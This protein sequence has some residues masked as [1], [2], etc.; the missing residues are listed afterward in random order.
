M[1]L[2]SDDARACC[3]AVYGSAAARF[4][5]GDSF[6]PGGARLSR[7][8]LEALAPR[9]ADTILDV[10]SG[11][12]SSALLMASEVGC[13]V[14]GVDIAVGAL[15]SATA[16]VRALGL[17]QVPRFV[18]AD[19][20]RLP[21][22]DASVDGALC[23]CSLCLFLDKTAAAREIARV[24]RPGA[25]LALSDVTAWPA[26]LPPAL[27]S[28]A[29]HVACVAGARPL[30]ETASLLERADLVIETVEAHDDAIGEM[31]ACIEARLRLA[32]SLGAGPLVPYLDEAHALLAAAAAALADGAIGYGVVIAR[33]RA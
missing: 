22:R 19:A 25:C 21:L 18:A 1:T 9:P 3:A 10:A 6:H 16:R 29:A 4:L 32:R 26:R 24:L 14:I 11:P 12:G 8:L 15:S 23:E 17:E 31:L 7:R 33:R 28:I 5:L 27:R 30:S 2:V 13:R 20:Q